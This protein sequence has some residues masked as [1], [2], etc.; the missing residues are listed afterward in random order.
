[1]IKINKIVEAQIGW[2]VIRETETKYNSHMFYFD[3]TDKASE[4]IIDMMIETL[5]C[6]SIVVESEVE[7]VRSKLAT[8][9]KETN[10]CTFQKF[11]LARN[12]FEAK[13]M[14]RI[15]AG[16]HNKNIVEVQ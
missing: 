2:E 14:F 5:M 3:V 1:M 11:H 10:C 6:C 4:D 16:M 7:E 8:I 12:I 15:Y 13:P 9:I